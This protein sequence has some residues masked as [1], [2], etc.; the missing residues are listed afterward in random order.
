MK[1]LSKVVQLLWKAY[2]RQLE[3]K[4]EIK[5]LN[6]ALSLKT[7]KYVNE[8]L[9]SDGYKKQIEQYKRTENINKEEI[10]RLHEKLVKKGHI[11]RYRIQKYIPSYNMPYDSV[12]TKMNEEYFKHFVEDSK[13]KMM[14]EMIDEG[15]VKMIDYNDCVEI[16]IHLAEDEK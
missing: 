1:K 11:I 2:K 7:I 16:A 13:L 8:Q 15:F 12:G 9:I 10:N 5:N 3:M 6:H 14:N 4:E